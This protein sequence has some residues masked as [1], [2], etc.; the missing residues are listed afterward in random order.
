MPRSS[1]ELETLWQQVNAE[2][3][4]RGFLVY[5]GSLSLEGVHANWPLKEGIAGFLALAASLGARVVYLKASPLEPS[6]LIDA[7]AS[8]LSGVPEAL[9]ADTPEEFM[10]MAGV[11]SERE[12]QDF[13]RQGKDHY[14]HLQSVSVEWVHEGVVHRFERYATWYGALIDMAADVADLVE[15]AQAE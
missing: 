2:V 8:F 12:V 14:G 6:D 4:Q 7:V 1:D 11:S 13:L 10:E 5:P 3:T 15:G 9:D